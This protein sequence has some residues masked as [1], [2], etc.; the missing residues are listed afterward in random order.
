MI[1]FGPVEPD[2]LVGNAPHSS[3]D[4][5]RLKQMSVTAVISLQSDHDLR[6][7]RIDWNKLQTAYSYSD[8]LVQ[9]YP[10]MDFDEADLG[11]KVAQPVKALNLLLT[12]G[13]RVYVHCNAGVCR[14]PAT[15]LGYLCFYRGMTLEQGLEYIRQNR[16]QANPYIGAVEKALVQLHNEQKAAT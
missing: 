4:V 14:A 10:I 2:I 11:N 16:P 3:V 12:G 6:T 1:N 9:R 7:H 13:H 15:V 5:A 8:I